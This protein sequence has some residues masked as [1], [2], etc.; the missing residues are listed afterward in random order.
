MYVLV[1]PRSQFA[2]LF[3]FVLALFL[4]SGSENQF[5]AFQIS[6]VLAI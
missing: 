4:G 6:F 5:W 1:A 2:G 3:S